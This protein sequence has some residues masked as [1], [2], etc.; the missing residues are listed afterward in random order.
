MTY[1]RETTS[2][3]GSATN[4]LV[5]VESELLPTI[6]VGFIELAPGQNVT[7]FCDGTL[8]VLGA[9]CSETS[10]GQPKETKLPDGGLRIESAAVTV[11]LFK[12]LNTLVPGNKLGSL[13]GDAHLEALAAPMDSL[14]GV[15]LGERSDVP[16][17]KPT[18]AQTAAEA[19]GRRMLGRVEEAAP[20]APAIDT[21]KV[22]PRTGGLPARA[23]IP[24]LLGASAVLRLVTRRAHTR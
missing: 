14:T 24:A 12:G 4:T 22:L 18:L 3:T 11:H 16:G 15:N 20:A 9:L 8:G 21:S 23:A 5:R 6:G 1:E 7:V 13:L 19:S 2:G 17:I 10:V